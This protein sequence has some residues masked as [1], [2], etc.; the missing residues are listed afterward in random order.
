M[1]VIKHFIASI[2]II[3]SIL[4]GELFAQQYSSPIVPADPKDEYLGIVFG[5]GQNYQSGKFYV[6]CENCEFESGVKT[7]F[8]IGLNYNR[9]INEY[10]NWGSLL[11]YE[12]F[13]IESK[14]REFEQFSYQFSPTE[15]AV[16]IPIEFRHTALADFGQLSLVPYIEILPTNWFF[17]RLGLSGGL[18]VGANINHTKELLLR[19]AVLDNGIS[20]DIKLA[21]T[22]QTSQV[23]E[24]GDFPEV[25]SF[26][27]SVNPMIGFRIPFSKTV[28]F[29]PY[30]MHRIPLMNMSEFGEDFKIS[31]YRI[32]F[33]LNFK[34]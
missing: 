27:L 15:D 1:R 24:D 20:V 31:S 34:L 30:Y 3:N 32:M 25:N 7:G 14:F 16:N 23:V 22:K 19:K 26:Q 28:L 33:E 12:S 18:V 9:Q 5:L 2:L 8:T 4:L 13:S 11:L 29:A 21:N 6:D 17:A 10:L